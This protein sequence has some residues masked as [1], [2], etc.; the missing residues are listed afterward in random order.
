MF[1]A[2]PYWVCLQTEK[3]MFEETVEFLFEPQ[4]WYHLVVAHSCGRPLIVKSECRVYVN[5]QQQAKTYLKYPKMWLKEFENNFVGARG[6]A[7]ITFA[8]PK[9]SS[10]IFSIR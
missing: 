8:P 4:R 10:K 2:A 3:G 6:P 5:G 7:T 1:D 9:K